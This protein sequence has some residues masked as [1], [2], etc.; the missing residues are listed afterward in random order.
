M[1][2]KIV[3][4]IGW[5][6]ALM[7]MVMFLSYIDQ[8]RLNV[9]GQIGSVILPIATMVNCLA[10]SSYGFLKP[11]KDWPMVISNSFG[12]ILSAIAAITAII[13]S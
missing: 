1:N 2:E 12:V 4:K 6:A 7:G 9:S 10:W 13:F 8:I 3:D 11:K 5:F